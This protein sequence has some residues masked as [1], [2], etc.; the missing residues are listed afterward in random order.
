MVSHDT[1]LSVVDAQED[2]ESE[3]LP[4]DGHR[5]V[6]QQEP[7]QLEVER[8]RDGERVRNMSL[9]FGKEVDD[10][11]NDVVAHPPVQPR[12]DVG[13]FGRGEAGEVQPERPALHRSVER[14]N[15]G[16]VEPRTHGAGKV[17]GVGIVE[18]EVGLAHVGDPSSRS[19]TREGK[20]RLAASA[21]DQPHTVTDAFDEQRQ[22]VQDR[23]VLEARQVVE[24]HVRPHVRPLDPAD[25][26]AEHVLVRRRIRGQR[27]ELGFEAG[28]HLVELHED[29]PPERVHTATIDP[30]HLNERGRIRGA[31]GASSHCRSAVVFP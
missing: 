29:V 22:P 7:A 15:L 31:A 11:R 19:P 28:P 6:A 3:K 27:D 14:R 24:D 17:A 20:R 26:R 4:D 8:R 10:L 9:A 2:A 30:P 21:D 16:G 18:G 12:D 25:E 23:P 5:L 1:V 13:R